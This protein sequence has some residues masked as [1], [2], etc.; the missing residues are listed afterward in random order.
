MMNV[1]SVLVKKLCRFFAFS[2]SCVLSL[3]SCDCA[4]GGAGTVACP[5]A[6]L[7][8]LDETSS[9]DASA[10]GGD[11]FVSGTGATEPRGGG[12]DAAGGSDV[13]L[14]AKTVS[15]G[16]RISICTLRESPFAGLDDGGCARLGAKSDS[17]FAASTV[18]VAAVVD[19]SVG[20]SADAEGSA[21]V[22]LESSA[23]MGDFD[24]VRA[25]FAARAASLRWSLACSLAFLMADL[26]GFFSASDP[27]GD[28]S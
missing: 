17:G 18:N 15:S 7:L 11:N 27:L 1:Q 2:P 14:E 23:G 3:L 8:M 9:W 4:G 19:V 12:C 16:G 20:C 25:L 22:S 13:P 6:G 28:E 5:F 24:A 10:T 26:D 21:E